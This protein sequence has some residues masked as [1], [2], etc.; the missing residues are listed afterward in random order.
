MQ[1]LYRVALQLLVG[2]SVFAPVPL[3]RSAL[4]ADTGCPTTI[5]FGETLLCSLSTPGEVASFSFSANGGDRIIARTG[6][7][8][9]CPQDCGGVYGYAA[10]V[11]GVMD[12]HTR[13][14]AMPVCDWL[15][16][17]LLFSWYQQGW[18]FC[19]S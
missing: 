8:R 19:S 15:Q 6:G 5:A 13:S 12:E 17:V 4:P 18:C 9:A 10:I 7:A 2:I 16:N 11:A 1:L 14:A 3:P